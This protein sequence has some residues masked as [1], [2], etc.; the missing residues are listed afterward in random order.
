MYEFYITKHARERFVERFSDERHKFSH[1][2]RCRDNDCPSCRELA[3][4]LHETTIHDRKKWDSV[5]CAKLHEAD[6]IKVF[7]NNS[8]FMSL[9]YT[10]YGYE[11]FHFFVEG[12]I[13]F[14]I[15]EGDEG[16][17]VLTC[18]SVNKPINN[19]FIMADFAR[20]PKFKK[21]NEQAFC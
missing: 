19:S 21:K 8:E 1:L 16:K 2:A 5:I 4:D 15:K 20:R 10:R 13:L 3:F 7:Q 12:E 11:R 6:E 9:L 14:V 18:M 17:I